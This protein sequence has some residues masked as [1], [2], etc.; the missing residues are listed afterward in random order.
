MPNTPPQKAKDRITREEFNKATT[1]L[2]VKWG[3]IIGYAN[4]LEAD[5]KAME[6]SKLKW[7]LD[8]YEWREDR[9]VSLD[10]DDE[11]ARKEGLARL[12]ELEGEG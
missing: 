7:E 11:A 3:R 8:V 4:Q 1:M 6:I 9:F 10:D 5:L 2:N 12:K